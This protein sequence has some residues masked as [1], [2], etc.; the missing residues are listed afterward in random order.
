MAADGPAM[1][2]AAVDA[3]CKAQ[4]PRRTIQGVA[5]AVAS[6]FAQLQPASANAKIRA[7][8]A[9]PA[10]RCTTDR[11]DVDEVT[12]DAIVE[13][14]KSVRSAKRKRKKERRMAARATSAEDKKATD[15]RAGPVVASQ[16]P[17]TSHSH[18]AIAQMPS[19][20]SEMQHPAAANAHL[21]DPRASV[22]IA[23]SSAGSVAESD[24]SYATRQSVLERV[25]APA[26]LQEPEAVVKTT[27]RAAPHR[28]KGDRSEPY[29]SS[30]RW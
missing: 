30:G 2:F 21:R 5:A 27:A 20:A 6:V 3:A 9:K 18:T 28:P 10:A 14:L 4:A 24:D 17:D 8:N 12:P 26:P 22:A 19:E 25:T 13:A 11:M 7:R 23:Q 1:I 15:G 16:N 29:R